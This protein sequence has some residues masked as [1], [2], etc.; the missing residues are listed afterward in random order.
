M[1]AY[2]LLDMFVDSSI[3]AFDVGYTVV[4]VSFVVKEEDGF[5]VL[6][7]KVVV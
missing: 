5:D 2:Q 7:A 3:K 1:K 6:E 4:G